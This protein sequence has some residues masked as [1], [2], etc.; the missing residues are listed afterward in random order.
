MEKSTW[1]EIEGNPWPTA[2]KDLNPPS[3]P[4]QGIHSTKNLVSDIE[5]IF[6]VEG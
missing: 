6:P 1:Q 5:N 2:H 4:L 3:S